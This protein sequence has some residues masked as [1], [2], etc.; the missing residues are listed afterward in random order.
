MLFKFSAFLN[1]ST[2]KYAFGFFASLL[3]SMITVKGQNQFPT[4][5]GPAVTLSWGGGN[6][7]ESTPWQLVFHDEFNG[8][9]INNDKWSTFYPYDG[10][11]GDN[12]LFC[13]THNS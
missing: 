3:V 5:T 2:L 4:G 7:C 6:M 9:T 10:S 12:C 13:R 1:A 11:G 8:N